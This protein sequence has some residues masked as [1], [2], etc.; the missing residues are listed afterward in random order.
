MGDETVIQDIDTELL[1]YRARLFLEEGRTEA[2]CALL[3]TIDTGDEKL[4]KDVAYLIG[5]CYVQ[6]RQWEDAFRL[7]SPLLKAAQLHEGEQEGLAD[8]EQFALHLLRL[9]LVAVNLAHFE[10]ASQHFSL[11]LKTLRDRRVHLQDVRIKARY[12]LAMTCCV[13]GMDAAC[14]QHY[15]EALRLCRQYEREEEVPDILYGLC[16]AYRRNKDYVRAYSTGQEALRLYQVRMDREME[17]RMHNMVG[18]VCRLLGKFDE[19]SDHFTDSLAIAVS[20]QG[21][22][23][24][25]LDCASL[26]ELRLVQGRLDEAQRYCRLAL[27]NMERSNNAYMRGMTYQSIGKVAYAEARQAEGPGHTELLE[28]ASAWF[29]KALAE[30]RTTQAYPDIGEVY[31]NWAQ[32]LE[33]LGRVQQAVECWRSAYEVLLPTKEAK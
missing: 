23:M 32:V 20:S 19:A 2:A 15:E 13:R 30:L 16:D 25:M 33:D 18:H 17:S 24:A 8:R 14:V 31:G 26:A 27:E 1:L 5:W 10:D 4:Q 7:L 22:T 6:R 21:A 28:K 11:C 12:Y 9:G 3:E 29:E